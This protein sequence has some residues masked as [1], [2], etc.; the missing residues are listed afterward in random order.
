MGFISRSEY[1]AIANPATQGFPTQMWFNRQLASPT[2]TLYPTPDG[3]EGPLS[4]YAMI[5]LQDASLTNDVQVDIPY[6]FLDAFSY[7]MAA[8]LAVIW[9]PEKV[10]M[11]KPLAD[12][13]YKIAASQNV[14][15]S[16]V[17]ISP[18]LN[19]YWRQ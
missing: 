18:M 4:F 14:E 10:A 1:A 2:I 3:N 13:A 19:S 8:R 12:E 9:A 7:E 6:Y 15:S 5:Q 11:L 16:A 17:Y